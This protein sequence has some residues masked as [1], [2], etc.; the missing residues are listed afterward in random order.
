MSAMIMKVHET[1]PFGSD[2]TYYEISM[3]DKYDPTDIHL[4]P[5]GENRGENRVRPRN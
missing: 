3:Y 5:Y 1:P 2:R 4:K